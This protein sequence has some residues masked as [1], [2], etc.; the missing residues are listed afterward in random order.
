V[1]VSVY[2]SYLAGKTFTVENI[3]SNVVTLTFSGADALQTPT[4]AAVATYP[5]Y[6]YSSLT[7][8]SGNAGIWYIS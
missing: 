5:I 6:P 8:Y 3:S 1:T 2:S 7:I 4:G